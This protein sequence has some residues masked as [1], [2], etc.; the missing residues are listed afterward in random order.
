MWN[1]NRLASREGGGRAGSSNYTG[2]RACFI[3]CERARPVT[4]PCRVYMVRLKGGRVEEG[5]WS[6]CHSSSL[7]PR[8]GESQYSSGQ[9]WLWVSHRNCVYQNCIQG[10]LRHGLVLDMPYW[11]SAWLMW[12]IPWRHI[13]CTLIYV[14]QMFGKQFSEVLDWFTS[15]ETKSIISRSFKRV[16]D[17]ILLYSVLCMHK[18]E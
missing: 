8:H 7:T 14:I 4:K 11:R 9:K 6:S 16:C 12:S 17:E 1:K 3:D 5:D 10:A 15:K 18:E 13:L 2:N